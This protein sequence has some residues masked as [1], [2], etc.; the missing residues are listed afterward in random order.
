MG[1]EFLLGS[2]YVNCVK[3]PFLFYLTTQR[4]SVTTHDKCNSGHFHQKNGEK[5]F[6]FVIAIYEV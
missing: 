2:T 6:F 1:K 4:L 5:F 3:M